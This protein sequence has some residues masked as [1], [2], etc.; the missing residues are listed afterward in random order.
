MEKKIVKIDRY[1]TYTD[2]YVYYVHYDDGDID[3]YPEALLTKAIRLW[4]GQS[5]NYQFMQNKRG[6]Y[7][8]RFT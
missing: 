7:F 5:E 6:V 8:H 2:D 3:Q 4:I 1:G